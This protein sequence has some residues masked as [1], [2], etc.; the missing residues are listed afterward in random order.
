MQNDHLMKDYSDNVYDH[1]DPISVSLQ[2]RVKF[3]GHITSILE[4]RAEV[5][6]ENFDIKEVGIYV[7]VSKTAIMAAEIER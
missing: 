4:D 7:R 3:G 2:E 6:D 1:L 5:D